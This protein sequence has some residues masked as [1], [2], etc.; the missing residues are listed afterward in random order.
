MRFT[1]GKKLLIGFSSVIILLAMISVIS[2]LSIK[3]VDKTYSDL[4]NRQA[5][6]VNH[7]INVELYA[8][9]EISSLRSVLVRPAWVQ[10][11]G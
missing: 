9:R 1:I 2:Y 10:S 4:V 3:N 8:S 7:A 11:I 5:V 6:I